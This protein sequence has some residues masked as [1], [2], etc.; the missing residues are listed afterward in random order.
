M[1]TD[2]V[3]RNFVSS[4]IDTNIGERS[5]ILVLPRHLASHTVG[6]EGLVLVDWRKLGI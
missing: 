3:G 2:L 6:L 5:C 1:T 4:A